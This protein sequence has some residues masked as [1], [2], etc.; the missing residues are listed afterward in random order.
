[1]PDPSPLQV[2]QGVLTGL[3]PRVDHVSE[4][5]REHATKLDAQDRELSALKATV[6]A[7]REM[8]GEH[9]R[10]QS[11][12]KPPADS[13]LKRNILD[14]AIAQKGLIPLY[15]LIIILG[16]K[17]CGL[18]VGDITSLWQAPTPIAETAP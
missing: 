4:T 9:R 2:L 3:I 14:P 15:A 10:N 17:S 11:A 13:W 5:V 8:C 1:M 7:H 16:A 6:E 12:P 18:D